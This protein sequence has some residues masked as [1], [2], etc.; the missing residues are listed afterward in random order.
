MTYKKQILFAF[1]LINCLLFVNF[2]SAAPQITIH[3]P[4]NITYD[5]NKILVNVTSSEPVDFFYKN[6]RG[7]NVILAENTTNFESFLYVKEG[8]YEYTIWAKNSNGEVNE[9]ISFNQ[10]MHNPVNVTACGQ[11]YS[12]DTKYVLGA[13]L[14]TSYYH[15]LRVDYIHNVSI[16]LNG[17][18]IFGLHSSLNIGD[19]SK[20]RIF[21]GSMV[22][23][24]VGLSLSYSGALTFEDLY[25]EAPVGVSEFGNY[26]IKFE[27]MEINVTSGDAYYAGPMAFLTW[28]ENGLKW[29]LKNSKIYYSGTKGTISTLFWGYSYEGD[30][31]FDNVN[32]SGFKYDIFPEYTYI[33]FYS[34]NS[35]LNS[36]SI[37]LSTEYRRGDCSVRYGNKIFD[38]QQLKINVKDEIGNP[39]QAIIE[40][41]DNGILGKRTLVENYEWKYTKWN[42]TDFLSLTT[43][44]TGYKELWLTEKLTYLGCAEKGYDFIEEYDFSPYTVTAKVGNV[45]QT[46]T[47]NLTGEGPFEL[48]FNLTL[49]QSLPQC[50]ISQML[51]LNGDSV[52]NIQDAILVLRHITNKDISIANTKNCEG[53]TL[54]PF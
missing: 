32:I 28:P 5:S 12:S 52:V 18:T 23:S 7:E 4:E 45:N 25:I 10:I 21:N 49:P 31:V 30:Y 54:N 43:D 37:L 14:E 27:N 9:S 29:T 36:T 13:D 34:R 42:P 47:L 20:S 38:Q 16:N 2:I 48:E 46:Q 33:N 22:S 17:Y 44:E 53:I 1:F 8:D 11:L 41:S 51:D 40:I 3:S 24:K 39:I 26:L 19:L 15:C 6:K 35:N 50:T